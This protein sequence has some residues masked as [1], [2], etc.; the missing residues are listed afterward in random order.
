[1]Q[2]NR[3][4]QLLLLRCERPAEGSPSV[5]RLYELG[6]PPTPIL[7]H[8]QTDASWVPEELALAPGGERV[9][10][11]NCGR[12]GIQRVVRAYEARNGRELWKDATQRTRGNVRL[13]MG[14]AGRAFGCNADPNDKNYR[15]VRLSDFQEIGGTPEGWQAVDPS[16]PTFVSNGWLFVSDPRPE[17]RVSVVTDW[18]CCPDSLTFSPNGKLLVWGTAEG[19]VLVADIQEVSRRLAPFRK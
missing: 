13:R 1:M 4:G 5:W 10:V 11:W 2:F 18:H 12:E 6:V 9:L 19:I 17:H 7:L 8:A 3:E 14:P 16:W 15:F